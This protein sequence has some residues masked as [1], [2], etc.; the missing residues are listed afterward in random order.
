[1]RDSLSEAVFV[2]WKGCQTHVL[3]SALF[4]DV[5]AHVLD[6]GVKAHSSDESIPASAW[7]PIYSLQG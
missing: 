7:K 4:G 6:G 5:S 2:S 1:M 3:L